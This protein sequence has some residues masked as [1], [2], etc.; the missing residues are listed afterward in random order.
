MTQK[1]IGKVGAVLFSAAIWA[2]VLSTLS[3]CAAMI[4][5][6][7]YRGSDGSVMKFV[8][9]YDIGASANAVDTIDN[10]RGINTDLK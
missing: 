8:T 9:G 10:R 5:I 2:L 6:K 7:E 3:G 4:G 1:A